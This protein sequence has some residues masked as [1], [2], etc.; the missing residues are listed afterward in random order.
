MDLRGGK[1]QKF[2][3]C[4]WYVEATALSDSN[5]IPVSAPGHRLLLGTSIVFSVSTLWYGRHL[6]T[7]S[8]CCGTLCGLVLRFG[9]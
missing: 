5:N 4:L 8:L 7:A 9:L 6:L 1:K 3:S 2:T